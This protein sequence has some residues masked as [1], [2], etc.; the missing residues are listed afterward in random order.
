MGAGLIAFFRGCSLAGV[1]GEG[2]GVDGEGVDGEGVDG[3][4]V[5]GERVDG[6][7][8]DGEGVERSWDKLLDTGIACGE[9]VCFCPRH[10]VPL[11]PLFLYLD[12]IFS[13]DQKAYFIPL[14]GPAFEE[15]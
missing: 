1:C 8:V 9:L 11:V 10:M 6:E 15:E 13:L 5:D 3:E 7:R 4:K 14:V 12:L 2:E